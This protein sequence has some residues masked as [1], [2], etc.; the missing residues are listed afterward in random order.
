MV[1]PS[2]GALGSPSGTVTFLFTDIEGSTRLWEEFPAEMEAALARH[3]A[4]LRAAIH[5]HD[6]YVFATGG[7]A[8]CAAF[9]TAADGVAAARNAQRAL[10]R[11]SWPG[12][13]HIKVRMALHTGA[14]ELRDSDYFG[15]P[16]NRVA[17]LL[18]TGHGGQVLLSLATEELV[19]DG[20]PTGVALRD[21]GERRLKDLIRPER[22]YQLVAPELPADFPPLRTLEARAH[23]LPIQLTSFVGR[24]RE[25]QEIKA[26][27]RKTRL[28]TL[29]GTGGSGKTRLSLQVG[30]DLVDD[31]ADGIWLVELAPLAE[32]KLVP[33]AVATV[34]GLKEQTGRSVT[35]TLTGHLKDRE[36]LLL[37]DNCE[38]LVEASAQLCQALLAACPRLHIL[39]TSRE[40]LRVPGEQSYRV[41]SLATPDPSATATPVALTP[42]AAVQLFID[43]AVAA[44]STFQVNNSNAP[45]V[46]SLC[47]HLD[48][49]PL[50]IELAAAR[51]RSMTTEEINNRL[52]QRFQLLTGGS[53]TALPRHQTLR[54]LIDWSY[55][56]LTDQERH[57]LARLSVFAGGW[58]LA[59]ARE[60]CGDAGTSEE[61]MIELLD[62]LADKSLLQIDEREGA[63]R[64]RLLETVRQYA[65]DRLMETGD[66]ATWRNRHL[67]H[68]VDLAEAM[69]PRLALADQK[70]A[71]DRLETEH[72]N[73]RAALA[74]T[75][76]QGG[77][78]GEGLRLASLLSF[79]WMV[80]GYL[81]EGRRWCS[82][83]LA[84]PGGALKYRA[85]ACGGAGTLARQQADYAEARAMYEQALAIHREVGNRRGI[86]DS[87][88]N[89]GLIDFHRGE[90]TAALAQLEDAVPI[91]RELGDRE[92]EAFALNVM[93][94][95]KL[96]QTDY[97]H[98]RKLL[99]Q[100][101][102]IRREM[103]HRIGMA[104]TLINLGNVV[105]MQ[106]DYSH[107]RR[108][109][110]E[111]LAIRRELG[112][113]RGTAGALMNLGEID[114]E[115]GDFS[116]A[117]KVF[118][119]CLAVFRELGDRYGI[120]EALANLGSVA[121]KQGD[122]A[123]ARA[124]LEQSL[125]VYRD[126]G[127]RRGISQSLN[128]LGLVT[129]ESGDRRSAHAHLAEALTM[130]RELGDRRTIAEA[131]RTLARMAC[132]LSGPV[133]AARIWGGEERLREEINTPIPPG[134]RAD[135]ERHVAA[136]RAAC[137]DDTAF[138]RAWQDGRAMP[139]EQVI[140]LALKTS[141]AD[142]KPL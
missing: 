29:T 19:R 89:L 76:G 40:A 58:T 50:A 11:E 53:R 77:D 96:S 27:L 25:M 59:A 68:F 7:D 107:A 111:G 6:G 106:G 71:F 16:L 108:I 94:M 4:L 70:K 115:T 5:D 139:L 133:Q 21:M 55:D 128:T 33:Q 30:A 34:L 114:L 69:H 99:E 119:E 46:A 137:A 31:F 97:P 120:G 39:A 61:S 87:L 3:D 67:S 126:T 103:G 48:G 51:V 82:T 110:E 109:Q 44:Q 85:G 1:A 135:Y 18:A 8:F 49:I 74:W 83:L 10:V 17:R 37:L 78:I 132:V 13:V 124:W 79:F 102:A 131:L 12:R 22:V 105:M 41:P 9:H 35:E 15:P 130:L 73:L 52:G 91:L 129:M 45:A 93:G 62:S 47:F 32:V 20:L 81:S 98:A 24:D 136:A 86:A 14:A 88:S 125:A 23:N 26:L 56:L 36:V 116:S 90:Y 63:T 42:F 57:L 104:V 121:V 2:G 113:R 38:H 117:G 95:V 134:D 92:A 101:L 60:V 123:A 65:R 100:S 138:D 122:F 75:S 118:E 84:R 112:D 72:D 127:D 141:H 43:R 66:E 64:Y 54:A 80:R 28:V 142:A 140:D